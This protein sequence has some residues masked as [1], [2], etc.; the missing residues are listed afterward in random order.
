M[1]KLVERVWTK[2]SWRLGVLMTG[3]GLLPGPDQLAIFAFFGVPQERQIAVLGITL[4]IIRS[5]V[6]KPKE[7]NV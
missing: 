2:H 5:F 7:P 1:P 4:L 6:Q 3:F